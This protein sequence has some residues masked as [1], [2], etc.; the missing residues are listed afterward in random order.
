MLTDLN[1]KRCGQHNST[2]R[3]VRNQRHG[4]QAAQRWPQPRADGNNSA[5]IR[6]TPKRKHHVGRTLTNA[7]A[8]CGWLVCLPWPA[9]ATR[10]ELSKRLVVAKFGPQFQNRFLFSRFFIE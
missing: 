9:S 4:T 2:Q 5:S 8:D 6:S 1:W 3:H 10:I 7:V